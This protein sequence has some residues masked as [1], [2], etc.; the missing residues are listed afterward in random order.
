[1]FVGGWQQ[2]G[3]FVIVG[4]CYVVRVFYCFVQY[5]FYV[6][7]QGVVGGVVQLVVDFFQV[8]EV[9]YDYVDWE[10]IFVFQVVQFIDYVCMV[11]QFGQFIVF[12]EEFQIG[13]GF[14]VGGDVGECYQYQVLVVFVF[15][16]DRKLQMDVKGFIGQ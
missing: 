3:E 11:V 4:L 1:M 9:S 8:I 12:V 13:F 15:G 5:F 7:Q 6:V 16:E 10:G 14:F 2:D